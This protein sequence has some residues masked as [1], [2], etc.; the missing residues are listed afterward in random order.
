MR[1]TR[2]GLCFFDQGHMATG[3]S[4]SVFEGKAHRLLPTIGTHLHKIRI[5]HEYMEREICRVRSR[6]PGH[7]KI[8]SIGDVVEI[9]SGDGKRMS[10]C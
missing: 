8:I 6:S 10:S 5:A 7:R 4:T 9:G 1:C 3:G 2:L